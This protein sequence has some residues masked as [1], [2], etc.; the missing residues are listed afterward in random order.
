MIH[1][2][3]AAAHTAAPVTPPTDAHLLTVEDLYAAT[4]AE[5][6]TSYRDEVGGRYVHTFWADHPSE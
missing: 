2:S 6:L 5:P 4:A 1:P 3:A